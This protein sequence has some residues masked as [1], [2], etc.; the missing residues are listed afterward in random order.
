MNEKVLLL[1][2]FVVPAGRKGDKMAFIQFM[3]CVA[4]LIAVDEALGCVF[5]R[6]AS[7]KTAEKEIDVDRLEKTSSRTAAGE[8][9]GVVSF[10]SNVNSVNVCP[11][12]TTVHPFTAELP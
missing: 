8:W 5:L 9:F 4:S 12:S 10:G 3:K 1:L 11:A 7:T 2:R 6:S